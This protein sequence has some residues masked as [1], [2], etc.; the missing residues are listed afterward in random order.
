M[1]NCC[2]RKI[3]YYYQ[4]WKQLCCFTFL[5]KPWFWCDTKDWSNGCW[6]FH[7]AI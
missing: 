2:S 1:M 4:F 6:K 7:F 3:S 5:W